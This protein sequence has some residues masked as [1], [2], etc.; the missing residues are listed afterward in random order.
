MRSYGAGSAYIMNDAIERSPNYLC[1]TPTI[2]V[3]YVLGYKRKAMD[4]HISITI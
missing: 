3:S 4:T 1:N 2:M